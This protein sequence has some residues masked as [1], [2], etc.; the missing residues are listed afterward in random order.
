MIIVSNN[1]S[2]ISRNNLG[3]IFEQG[4]STKGNARGYGLHIVK[5]ITQNYN[6]EIEVSSTKYKTEFF[7]IFP[8]I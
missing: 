3:K 5:N 7:I 6:A 1:G 2:K 4:Y 8:Q